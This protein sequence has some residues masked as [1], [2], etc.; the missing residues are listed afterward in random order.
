MSDHPGIVQRPPSFASMLVDSTDR[1][2]RG[3]PDD[4]TGVTVSSNWKLNNQN[5]ALYGYFT[6]LAVTQVQLQYNLPTI[7]GIEE[8][9]GSGNNIFYISQSN[10]DPSGNPVSPFLVVINVDNGGWF[11]YDE[12]AV[13][14][15]AALNAA[16]AAGTFTCTYSTQTGGFVL[17]NATNDFFVLG[18]D[19]VA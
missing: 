1:Y 7:V 15:A 9:A 18:P 11:D 4:A 19:L 3:Y 6:R 2:P 16:G 13:A 12:L 10:L 14:I 5:A 17:A 8:A